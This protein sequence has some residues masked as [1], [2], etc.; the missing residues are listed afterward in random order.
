MVAGR[1]PQATPAAHPNV[2]DDKAVLL[3]S[4]ARPR[5]E[6]QG[7]S[8]PKAVQAKSPQGPANPIQILGSAAR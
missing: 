1:Y 2:R 7:L 8:G 4:E 5:P 6:G 3:P